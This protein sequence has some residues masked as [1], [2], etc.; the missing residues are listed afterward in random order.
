MVKDQAF[1][2]KK[3]KTGTLKEKNSNIVNKEPPELKDNEIKLTKV[4]DVLEAFDHKN[5]LEG[6][7]FAFETII[8]SFNS[9]DTKALKNLLTKDVFISFQSAIKNEM[10]NPG[11][12][13]YS[14]TIDSVED[15][16]VEK[17]LIFITLKIT[18]EQFK[19]SDEATIIKKQDIWTFQKNINDKSPIW[20]L[21]ST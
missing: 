1:R 3:K 14:L 21:S 5:F 2:A 18:S 4:Y 17:N 8:N 13:F 9:N 11:Y 20:L 19:D 16:A 6:A 15:V 7:K 12:E 10:N